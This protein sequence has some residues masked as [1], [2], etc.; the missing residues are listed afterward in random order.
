MNAMHK[1]LL[2]VVPS[3]SRMHNGIALSKHTSIVSLNTTLDLSQ[4]FELPSPF[5]PAMFPVSSA[6]KGLFIPLHL[7]PL[8]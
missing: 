1:L 8:T 7:P 5:C 2:N 6:T 4:Q 3:L